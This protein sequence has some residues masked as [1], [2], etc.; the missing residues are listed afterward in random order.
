MPKSKKPTHKTKPQVAIPKAQKSLSSSGTPSGS[1]IT[2]VTPKT[3]AD[4]GIEFFQ[5]ASTAGEAPIR[6]YEL[7]LDADG[8]PHK[9]RSVGLGQPFFVARL[10]RFMC[11]V[12]PTP[13]CLRSIYSTRLHER[14]YAR[15][16]EWRLH[17]QLSP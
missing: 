12:Y 10:T 14:G 17:D 5:S 4:E 2:P 15:C 16:Q 7:R 1:P 6:V 13:A 11:T 9:D 8:G 3:P